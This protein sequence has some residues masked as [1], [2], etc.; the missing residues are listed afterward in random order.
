MSLEKPLGPLM[1]RER[2]RVGRRCV[3]A[4]HEVQ[5]NAS[6]YRYRVTNQQFDEHLSFISSLTKNSSGERVP[7]ITFDDGHRS[8]YEEAF[9]I[10]EQHRLRAVFFVIAGRISTDREFMTWNQTR[11]LVAA[12]HQVQSHGWAH[13]LLTRCSENDLR[14][15]LLS[16]KCELED[17]LG[18]D[19]QAISAPGGRWNDKVAEACAKAGYKQLFHSNPWLQ[20]RNLFGIQLQ[21]RHMVTG[22]MGQH[23]LKSLLRMSQ[24]Q[25]LLHRTKYRVKEQVR[26]ILGDR[27]YHKMWIKLAKWKS[28]EG[29]EV[30]VS[31]SGKSE[32]GIQQ[33]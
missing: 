18:T 11:E 25:V 14:Q 28:E 22:G 29:I 1:A 7:E 26:V 23:E 32:R 3:L 15:E 4:Y 30:D 19:V 21:G 6:K 8:N 12:G 2:I 33:S 5:R 31:E 20:S 17:R 24:S 10:L 13:R 9:P 16:S 27:L